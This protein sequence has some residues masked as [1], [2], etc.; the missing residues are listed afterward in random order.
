M[1]ISSE[2]KRMNLEFLLWKIPSPLDRVDEELYSRSMM[3]KHNLAKYGFDPDSVVPIFERDSKDRWSQEGWLLTHPSKWVY[4]LSRRYVH[5]TN[6]ICF[7][8]RTKGLFKKQ[9]FSVAKRDTENLVLFAQELKYFSFGGGI[10][11]VYYATEEV[12]RYID[13]ECGVLDIEGDVLL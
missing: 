7:I 1:A 4:R 9:V 13:D 12:R 6:P 2:G 5:E 8:K 3:K 10:G 11:K